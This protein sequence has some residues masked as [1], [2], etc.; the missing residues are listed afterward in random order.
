M[1]ERSMK[2]EG[3][4]IMVILSTFGREDAGVRGMAHVHKT[5]TKNIITEEI[6]VAIEEV[7]VLL[8]ARSSESSLSSEIFPTAMKSRLK[9]MMEETIKA[10]PTPQRP[11]QIILCRKVPPLNMKMVPSSQNIAP[12]MNSARATPRHRLRM[13]LLQK[14]MKK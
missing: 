3:S 9:R 2:T 1:K 7:T 5:M 4:C 11:D 12:E 13:M 6:I 14:I 8:T 10:M